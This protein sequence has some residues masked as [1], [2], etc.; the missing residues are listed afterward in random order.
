MSDSINKKDLDSLGY[1]KPQNCTS[2]ITALY[3]DN[4]TAAQQNSILQRYWMYTESRNSSDIPLE[5]RYNLYNLYDNGINILEEDDWTI[6]IGETISSYTRIYLENNFDEITATYRTIDDVIEYDE[7]NNMLKYLDNTSPSSELTSIIFTWLNKYLKLDYNTNPENA[8]DTNLIL[9]HEIDRDF[10]KDATLS[11]LEKAYRNLM[12]IIRV[13]HDYRLYGEG[14]TIFGGRANETFGT[15]SLMKD[16]SALPANCWKEKTLCYVIGSK[17]YG[18]DIEV[19]QTIQH[20]TTYISP[21]TSYGFLT[22]DHTVSYTK[23]DTPSQLTIGRH[24]AGRGYFNGTTNIANV[25]DPESGWEAD[26]SKGI[27][28]SGSSK[29]ITFHI[30]LNNW[31][32]WSGYTKTYPNYVESSEWLSK[33]DV[34]LPSYLSYVWQWSG[35]DPT[36]VRSPSAYIKR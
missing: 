25:G 9:T 17:A 16:W 6:T 1:D 4:K 27:V 7:I 33:E 13:K 21:Y 15:K 18:E 22:H 28:F 26:G 5:S 8:D 23:K 10:V 24:S 30:S 3:D 12:Q 31:W 36:T 29:E 20:A 14:T 11:I 34:K 2:C 19:G 35:A 32:K